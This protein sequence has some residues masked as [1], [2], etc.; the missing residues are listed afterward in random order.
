MATEEFLLQNN[1]IGSVSAV[2]G[3]RFDPCPGTVG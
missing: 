1:G 2:Q 3:H